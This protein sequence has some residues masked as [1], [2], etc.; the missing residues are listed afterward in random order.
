[1]K[2]HYLASLTL[3][4]L[5]LSTQA[6]EPGPSSPYQGQT[7][8]WLTLQASGQMTSPTPQKASAA[9]REQAMRRLLESTYPIPEFFK[10][11][12]AGGKSEGGK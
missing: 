10:A 4:A 1:M 6:I 11:Q 9:E 7:E 8:R 5:P 12:S 2:L 3:L